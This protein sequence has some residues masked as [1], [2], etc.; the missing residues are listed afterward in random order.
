MSKPM[1]AFLFLVGL[2]LAAIPGCTIVT[3]HEDAA[4]RALLSDSGSADQNG[5]GH[6]GVSAYRAA[7]ERMTQT[8]LAS[9]A[10]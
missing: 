4:P 10:R 1:A 3:W 8:A 6:L 5:A 7:A 9:T 2:L